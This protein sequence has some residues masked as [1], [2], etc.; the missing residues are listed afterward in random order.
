VDLLDRR[1]HV[2][3]RILVDPIV[4]PERAQRGVLLP[5][6]LGLGEALA[7]GPQALVADAMMMPALHR[8]TAARAV[9]VLARPFV[10]QP[11]HMVEHPRADPGRPFAACAVALPALPMQIVDAGGETEARAGALL[12]LVEDHAVLAV[13]HQI[14]LDQGRGRMHRLERDEA[15]AKVLIT[16]IDPVGPGIELALVELDG[17]HG[18]LQ[19]ARNP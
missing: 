1:L 19:P 10:V 4:G 17:R 13:L 15:G 18:T 14:L 2:D 12:A 3:D 16:K 6:L 11:R 9:V 5:A 8:T 7:I